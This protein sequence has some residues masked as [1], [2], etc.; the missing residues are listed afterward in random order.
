MDKFIKYCKKNIKEIS[1][2]ITVAIVLTYIAC[3][4]LFPSILLEVSQNIIIIMV[5]IISAIIL[6]INAKKINKV[7]E[8]YK[9]L[10]NKYILIKVI[11][12]L[13]IVVILEKIFINMI[14]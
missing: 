1:L 4:L 7:I 14:N 2:I 11:S 5:V 8:E 10:A 3:T 12:F 9:K 6:T 13:V